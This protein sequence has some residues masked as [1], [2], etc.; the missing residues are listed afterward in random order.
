MVQK[1]ANGEVYYSYAPASV[2]T[3]TDK[4]DKDNTQYIALKSE[5]NGNTYT[6]YNATLNSLFSYS[7]KTVDDKTTVTQKHFSGKT[8]E[9]SPT[10]NAI[11]Y[12]TPTLSFSY[13][14]DGEEN[15]ATSKIV[16]DNQDILSAAIHYDEDKDKLSKSYNIEGFAFSTTY[17]E[18]G[19]VLSDERNSYTYD[20]LGELVQTNG[21]VNA[22][23]TYD[24]RG[25]MLSRT[26]NGEKTVFAYSNTQWQDQLTSVNGKVLTY[27]ANGNLQSYDG[28]E[29]TWS[30]GKQLSS[31]TNGDSTFKYQYDLNGIRSY[32]T[33]NGVTTKF[34]TLNGKILAQSDKNNKILF[35]YNGDAPIGFELNETQYFYLTNLSGDVVGITDADGN[36]IAKYSYDEWGKLLSI[37]TAEDSNAEQL[38]IAEANPLRYRGYYYDSETGMYYLQSRYYNPEFCR[39]IS[40]D[41][42][43]YADTSG[44]LNAN[45]YMYCWNNAVTFK[46]AEGTTPKLAI[47]FE[48]IVVYFVNLGRKLKDKADESAAK[49]KAKISKLVS[50]WDK[51][52][53]THYNAF[54]D[55]LEYAIN[56]PDVVI[57]NFFSKIGKEEWKVRFRLVEYIRSKHEI[58]LNWLKAPIK[59]EQSA[60]LKAKS[61]SKEDNNAKEAIAQAILA[62]F[63]L[64][65]INEILKGF[66]T[67]LDELSKK[68]FKA[69]KQICLTLMTTY[70]VIWD[71]LF[72]NFSLDAL[73]A[74]D[75]KYFKWAD[76]ATNG[77]AP[78]MD[79]KG[80][81]K[82]F[83]AFVT[84]FKLVLNLDSAGE[85]N[86]DKNTDIILACVSAVAGMVTVFFPESIALGLLIT[87]GT[88]IVSKIIALMAKGY[89]MP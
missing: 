15:T 52:I 48:D 88:D 85:G 44:E 9:M 31:I 64:N 12:T 27:D 59:E 41:G 2:L 66:K 57:N 63:E 77:G 10:E 47:S 60:P 30:H 28:A 50:K 4:T 55:K 7:T 3:Y 49:T 69:V 61:K 43:E 1:Y 75:T 29:Y 81:D 56:Y 18:D 86:L 13:T 35:Q 67:S 25:N 72:G 73:I 5:E 38:A 19:N 22:A 42:F 84:L 62:I 34:D 8:Y 68:S 37:E 17:D 23:Y 21:A 46:D 89:I 82:G 74:G 39:F 70:N 53:K 33:V 71:Y 51:S 76:K 65:A 14:T 45:L 54:V 83:G 24:S 36:L 32:K 11:N 78:F 26:V 58:S 79:V 16:K 20:S 40:A 87:S 6:Q 80:I